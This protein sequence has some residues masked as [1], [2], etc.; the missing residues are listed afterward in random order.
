MLAERLAHT[1]KGVAGNIRAGQVHAA[2]G[3]LEEVI[4]HQGDAAETE[5]ALAQVARATMPKKVAM[6]LGLRALRRMTAS[7]R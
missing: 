3:L 5:T 6:S 2:A 7:R 4:R 1:L